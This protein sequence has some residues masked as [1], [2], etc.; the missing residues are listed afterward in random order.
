MIHISKLDAL[1]NR[2]VRLTEKDNVAVALRDT[3]AGEEIYPGVESIERI[4]RKG[5]PSCVTK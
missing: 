5:L 3:D 1:M 4:S 2:S